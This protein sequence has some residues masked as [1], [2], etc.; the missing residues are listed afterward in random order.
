MH[1]TQHLSLDNESFQKGYYINIDLN[2]V[3]LSTE[4]RSKHF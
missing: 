4:N 1:L 3:S 2:K